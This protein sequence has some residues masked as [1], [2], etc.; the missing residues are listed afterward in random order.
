MRAVDGDAM[1]ELAN[2]LAEGNCGSA[3]PW[4]LAAAVDL[5]IASFGNGQ[6]RRSVD[7]VRL[8]MRALN[9]H[10]HFY[11]A[12]RLG[13]AWHACVGLDP[14]IAKH[15]AQAL[16]NLSGLDAAERLLHEALS[17]AE[18]PGASADAMSE[19]V[20]YQGLLGR[21]DKQRFVSRANKGSLVKATD[22][23]LEQFHAHRD[24][25]YWLAINA[26]ALMSRE[27]KEG[28]PPRP[29]SPT[30]MAQVLCERLLALHANDPSDSWLCSTLS[31]TYLALGEC[32][33]AEFWL[34]RFLHHPRTLPFH[35][36]SYERQLREIWQGSALGTGPEC[37]NRLATII[38]RY[39]LRSE[40]RVSISPG[41]VQ[42]ITE[43]IAKRP[44]ELEKNFAGESGFSLALL[45]RMVSACSSIGCVTKR[46]MERLGTGFLVA[47]A[48]INPAWGAEP[49]FV[50]NAHVISEEVA[51]AIPPSDALVTFEVECATAPQPV[52]HRIAEVL[53]TS[54]PGNLGMRCARQD[55][56]DVTIVRL[57]E[58]TTGFSGLAT[59]RALPLVSQKAKT[60]V[61]GH[62]LGSG[63][64]ISLHDSLLLDIDD[65]GRLIHYRTPTDPGSSGSPVF[66]SQWEVI[67][68]HHGG[69]AS[70]PRLRGEG[71]YEA[72]E[73]IAFHAVRSGAS[74]TSPATSQ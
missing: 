6:Q 45:Q 59:A 62:P 51:G 9:A 4:E 11:H 43:A 36:E 35:V 71:C 8:A 41:R 34:Y 2:S 7:E 3:P 14:T 15:Q 58:T 38:A 10:R 23:Y 68:V 16:I 60:Y 70:M 19:I 21:I 69:S 64:Q 32:E 1:L 47:G 17:A 28:L 49:V 31:E 27:L 24:K 20:E 37:A 55:S 39:V 40:A 25:P 30:Q 54:A 44:A 46:G 33:S 61:V 50:T 26:I 67:G 22:R 48:E 5:L 13:E 42:A 18:A 52:F 63:L 74:V 72:N 66:N 29:A 12:Q 53:F 65:D 73:G 57:T 56:L